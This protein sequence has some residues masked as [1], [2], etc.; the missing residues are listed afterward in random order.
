MSGNIKDIYKLKELYEERKPVE[1]TKYDVH[2]IA[3]LLKLFLRELSEPLFTHELYDAFTTAIYIE[4]EGM[5]LYCIREACTTLPPAN[6]A[7]AKK[8]FGFLHKLIEHQDKSKMNRMF[9]IIYKIY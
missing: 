9:F 3:G 7:I 5:A 6:K 8:L 4:N 2:S 1:L